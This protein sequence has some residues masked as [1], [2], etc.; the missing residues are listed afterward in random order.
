MYFFISGVRVR[1]AI[2]KQKGGEVSIPVPQ[3]NDK[4]RAEVRRRIEDGTYNL[5]VPVAET[6]LTKLTV[7]K[8]GE[9]EQKKIQL[10]ARKI[11]LYDIR[12]ETLS[13]NKHL[14]R[15]KDDAYYAQLPEE[16]VIEELKKINEELS[17]DPEEMRV[18]LT[19]FQRQ[20]HWLLWHDH[21]TLA[22]YW[23]HAVLHTR[24]V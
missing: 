5:G 11:P 2:R 24:N 16:K 3:S 15:L 7:N 6:E 21:S 17:E 8:D 22:N 13:A 12:R 4:I 20:R 9:V 1:R 19:K 14:L 10:K 18:Q 23:S